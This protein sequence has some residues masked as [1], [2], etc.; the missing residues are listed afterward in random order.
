MR[1]LSRNIRSGYDKPAYLGYVSDWHVIE[2]V[3]HK[4]WLMAVTLTCV[5]RKC[6][7]SDL[8]RERL[9]IDVR[10]RIASGSFLLND[11]SRTKQF[12]A[13]FHVRESLTRVEDLGRQFQN[14]IIVTVANIECSIGR[15]PNSMRPIKRRLPRSMIE[16][17]CHGFG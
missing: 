11:A 15:N 17:G 14:S 12:L 7:C 3:F 6:N 8:I 5:D 9:K 2:T 10:P 13:L 16:N 4:M 1:G